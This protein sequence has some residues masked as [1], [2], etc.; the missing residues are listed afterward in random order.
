MEIDT[1]YI[2]AAGLGTRMGR[3]GKV[4]PKALWP[5]FNKTLLEW[6]CDF[7]YSLGIKKIF[8]NTH[9]LYSEIEEFVDKKSKY[10][11]EILHEKSLLGTGGAVYNLKQKVDS[12]KNVLL[13]N[14][15]QF[16]FFDKI[17]FENALKK[18]EN[19]SVCLFTLEVSRQSNYNRLVI[20]NELLVDILK[21]NH[22]AEYLTYSGM[23][24][25]NLS[26]LDELNPCRSS[27][28]ETVAPLDSKSCAIEIP[29]KAEYWDFGTLEYFLKNSHRAKMD[30]ANSSNGL[31]ASF[32]VQNKVDKKKVAN[33][34]NRFKIEE[35]F[36]KISYGDITDS[37]VVS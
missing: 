16:F 20:E 18:I 11:I 17:H 28:F 24:L 12:A 19:K 5:L 22:P 13:L 32:L 35:D 31:L 23:S 27:F 25:L 29:L 34:K 4:L 9:Y 33:L 36:S 2:L 30:L 15:D 3:I 26:L 7:A 14:T 10:N 21:E 1:C 8:I 6:Q 37:L